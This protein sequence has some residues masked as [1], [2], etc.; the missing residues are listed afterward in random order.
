[1]LWPESAHCEA[2]QACMHSVPV[3]ESEL[4]RSP[5]HPSQDDLAAEQSLWD[6]RAEDG[7][8]LRLAPLDEDLAGRDNEGNRQGGANEWK[9][10]D[11]PDEWGTRNKTEQQAA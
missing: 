7:P 1:M 8:G 4:P 9:E 11:H 10:K 5:P 6:G 3:A 2:I